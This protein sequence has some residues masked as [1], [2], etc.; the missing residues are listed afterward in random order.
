MQDAEHRQSAGVMLYNLCYSMVANSPAATGLLADTAAVHT[1]S[2]L[3][4]VIKVDQLVFL[5]ISAVL[6]GR[7]PFVL[8]KLDLEV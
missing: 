6:Q 2:L 1:F 4:F 7:E 3:I 5:I 8:F